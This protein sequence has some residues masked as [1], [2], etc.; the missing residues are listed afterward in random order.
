MVSQ[1]KNS[2]FRGE[3]I[4][5]QFWGNK[6]LQVLLSLRV[7]QAEVETILTHTC[8]AVRN[9][10]LAVSR[11]WST[12]GA[13]GF[14]C[15]GF[16]GLRPNTCRPAVDQTKLPVAREK[17]PLVPRAR[18]EEKAPRKFSSLSYLKTLPQFSTP[19]PRCL[20]SNKLF[21]VPRQFKS[22]NQVGPVPPPCV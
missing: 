5:Y 17:K 15:A 16:F 9:P 4:F 3:R 10:F 8:L 7:S 19:I 1:K 22:S 2:H 20:H 21:S 11:V 14:S 18:F 13:R 6:K 12:L